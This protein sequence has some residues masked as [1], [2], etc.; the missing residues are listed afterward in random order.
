[1]NDIIRDRLAGWR[2]QLYRHFA[3]GIAPFWTSRGIDQECGGY[4][5]CF[6]ADGRLDASDMDKY[7]VTQTRMIWGFSLFHACFPDNPAYLNAARQGV[8]F[9]IQHFWDAQHGGWYWK[10]E[11]TGKM[12][13]DGKVVYG[14]SFALYALSQYT[15]CTGDP[16]GLDYAGRTFDL[17]QKHCVDTARGGYYENLEPDWQ[18]SA[19][20]FAAGDRKSLDIHMHLLEGYTAL[21]QASGLAVH[22]RR[23]EEVID[24]I[25]THMVH[26]V[27]GCGLNQFNV[28]FR[29]IP[30]IAIRRTWNAEREGKLAEGS[31]DTTSYGHNFEL[32]WLLMQA[33]QAMGVE[34]DDYRTVARRLA[35]HALRYGIDWTHGG[36]YRDGT[37]DEPAVVRDKEWWQNAEALVGLI[38]AYR[39]FGDQ[40]YLN[41]F[42]NVWAFAGRHF[43]NHDLGE[44][45]QLL[46][47]TGQPL[48]GDIGN[49]WKACYHTGRAVYETIKRIDAIL[50][51]RNP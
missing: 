29:P 51:D 9:F 39:L 10:T 44:W 21:Y 42:E 23:L 36:V 47:E 27:H 24:V 43:I 38:D 8:D 12:L 37:H 6:D 13:D 41:A 40:R 45:R 32:A 49:P 46:T 1:M 3:E 14:Q 50:A 26:P 48:V 7:I 31:V 34:R 4:L 16:R 35:D 18:L 33:A 22:R 30:P 28:Y 19:P 17:L 5:T 15:L 25:L 2:E 11:R 20:G